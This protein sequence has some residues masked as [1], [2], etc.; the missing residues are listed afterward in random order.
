MSAK[1][2]GAEA[3]YRKLVFG[4]RAQAQEPAPECTVPPRAARAA[5]TLPC[6]VSGGEDF[7]P[8]DEEKA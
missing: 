8:H 3:I 4:E 7:G 5:G 2:T 1:A 6:G